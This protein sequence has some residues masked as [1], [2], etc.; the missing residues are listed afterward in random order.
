MTVCMK[1]GSAEPHE[2]CFPAIQRCVDCDSQYSGRGAGGTSSFYLS[3]YACDHCKAQHNRVG[4]R[5]H[6]ANG[7]VAR[8]EVQRWGCPSTAR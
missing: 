4:V 8:C 7:Y 1:C 6:S 5:R 2:K 3:P